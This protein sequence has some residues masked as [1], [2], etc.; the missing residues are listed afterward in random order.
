MD[1]VRAEKKV[2]VNG[3]AVG[4]MGNDFLG[5]LLD[6]FDGDA[7][8]EVGEI[9]YVRVKNALEIA[10]K[11]IEMAIVENLAQR[12]I[13]ESESF[14]AVG[15]DEGKLVDGVM[16]LFDVGEQAEAFGGVV[17]GSEE[18][19]H[20]ARGADRTG[21]FDDGAGVSGAAAAICEGEAGN[22]GA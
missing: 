18:I 13:G 4:E 17:A 7:E 16:D 1:T 20:V 5:V 11:E 3:T 10:A 12:V 8:A 15:V 6:R 2:S 14:V 21:F 22:A 9:L 19:D